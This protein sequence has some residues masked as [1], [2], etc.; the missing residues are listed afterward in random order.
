M[1]CNGKRYIKPNA[2]GLRGKGSKEAISLARTHPGAISQLQITS[3]STNVSGNSKFQLY[4]A[5]LFYNVPV[6]YLCEK[7]LPKKLHQKL[8]QAM[9]GHFHV[10]AA[11]RPPSNPKHKAPLGADKDNLDTGGSSMSSNIGP[12]RCE[13]DSKLQVTR[14]VQSKVAQASDRR[15]PHSTAIWGFG[16]PLSAYNLS[17]FTNWSFK[18]PVAVSTKWT[19]GHTQ[20]A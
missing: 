15:A 11:A 17:H 1:L 19:D 2:M 12:E 7:Q 6:T 8:L 9:A 16:D 18:H 3:K 4:K 10:K 20:M 5:G 13:N 14:P